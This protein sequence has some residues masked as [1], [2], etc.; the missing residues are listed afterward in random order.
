MSKIELPEFKSYEGEAALWDN[1]DTG[2]FMKDDGEW[3]HFDLDDEREAWFRF[4][5][6]Q[7]QA[8][9]GENEPEYTLD[10][11]RELNPEYKP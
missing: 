8:A 3:F 9:Y 10:M 1:L 2:N 4:A 5:A 11:I 6:E 7:F